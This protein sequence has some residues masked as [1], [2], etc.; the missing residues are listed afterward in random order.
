MRQRQSPDGYTLDDRLRAGI[1]D[2][3]GAGS[4]PPGSLEDALFSFEQG[5]KNGQQEHEVPLKKY[6]V[7]RHE[8][9]SKGQHNI[10]YAIIVEE[11]GELEIQAGAELFFGD[12][13]FLQSNGGVVKILGKKRERVIIAS[14]KGIITP[15]YIRFA[16]KKGGQHIVQHCDFMGDQ[17][18]GPFQEEN[19]YGVFFP[20]S[21]LVVSE[22]DVAIDD[23]NFLVGSLVRGGV[24]AFESDI[25]ISNSSFHGK[26]SGIRV[27]HDRDFHEEQ[28]GFYATDSRVLISGCKFE[29]LL[30]AVS[31]NDS[32][33]E[34]QDCEI[35]RCKGG[36]FAGMLIDKGTVSAYRIR[37]E[38][39]GPQ[40]IG[41]GALDLDNT[42]FTITDCQFTRN[43]SENEGGAI[44]I[45]WSSG[46]I[47]GGNIY[48]NKGDGAINIVNCKRVDL[49]NV[50]ISSN[51]NPTHFG[52]GINI[53]SSPCYITG[54][55]IVGNNAKEYGGIFWFG[56]EP[57]IS[58][59]EIRGNIPDPE[60]GGF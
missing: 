23:V 27:F 15:G 47:L 28:Y 2:I 45:R 21:L 20:R 35:T 41:S 13:C 60:V 29:T 6:V 24:A 33:S 22:A 9:I 43:Q 12:M 42:V 30:N 32:I 49:E 36:L 7:K 39:N 37:F 11:G 26:G 17:G 58:G 10:D 54:G 48:N 18:S 5:N 8:V 40:S 52:G 55:R 59:T 51:T 25:N 16:G 4:W 53:D 31:L 14:K 3:E 38:D 46:R 1:S 56:R 44:S 19:P 50:D 57:R 34:I